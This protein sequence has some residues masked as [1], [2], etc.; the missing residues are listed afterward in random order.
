MDRTLW[1]SCQLAVIFF[2]LFGMA[3]GR[4]NPEWKS[5]RLQAQYNDDE[6][7][8]RRLDYISRAGTV[9]CPIEAMFCGMGG[10]STY[11]VNCCG[12]GDAYEADDFKVVDGV[13]YAVLTCNDPEDC[14]EIVGKVPRSP[15]SMFKIPVAKTLVNHDPVNDTGHGWIWIAP[16]A[17]DENDDPIIYC[18]AAPPGL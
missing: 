15:G 2:M 9:L 6:Q 17:T 4:P 8:L 16:G 18:W 13:A 5:Q 10:V 12:Q 7:T 14:R 3:H 11:H 1:L